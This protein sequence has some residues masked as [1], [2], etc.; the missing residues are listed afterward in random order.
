MDDG[1]A[2]HPAVDHLLDIIKTTL[3][4]PTNSLIGAL[5]NRY[6]K[7][8]RGSDNGNMRCWGPRIHMVF[9][10]KCAIISCYG[11]WDVQLQYPLLITR[12]WFVYE[13]LT[14]HAS[15]AVR[16]PNFDGLF[17]NFSKFRHA[18]LATSRNI[19]FLKWVYSNTK[20]I[21]TELHKISRNQ[22][23]WLSFHLSFTK[24]LSVTV[25]R[26]YCGHILILFRSHGLNQCWPISMMSYFVTRPHCQNKGLFCLSVNVRAQERWLE[27]KAEE[28]PV[29]L[30]YM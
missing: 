21:N 24:Y 18:P 28:R 4:S 10:C 7:E 3:G 5:L 25:I 11:Y 16:Q 26:A 29:L 17:F 12:K 27:T 20:E 13:F 2:I 8:V 14:H 30:T 19:L 1:R 15:R 6:L 9:V 23:P 22:K